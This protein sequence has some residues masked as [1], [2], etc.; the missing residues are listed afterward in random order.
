M[1]STS[2]QEYKHTNKTIRE[3]RR[4]KE[5][6]GNRKLN[7]WVEKEKEIWDMAEILVAT[8]VTKVRAGRTQIYCR[9]V[10]KTITQLIIKKTNNR[11]KRG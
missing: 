4:S 8:T 10:N 11:E 9:T 3:W 1:T 5:K 7:S 2:T 6:A